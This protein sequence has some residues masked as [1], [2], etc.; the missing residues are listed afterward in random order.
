[1]II[2]PELLAVDTTGDTNI[3][4]RMMMIVA[5]LDNMRRNFPSL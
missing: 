3:E 2:Y 1:M 4:D 5:R